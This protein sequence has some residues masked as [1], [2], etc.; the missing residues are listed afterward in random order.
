MYKNSI[1]QSRMSFS[2]SEST[3]TIFST[4]R[5]HDFDNSNLIAK[6]GILKQTIFMYSKTDSQLVVTKYFD[7]TGLCIEKDEFDSSKLMAITNYT[8]LSSLL[9]MKHVILNSN[10][11]YNDIIITYAYDGA[12]NKTD[13]KTFSKFASDSTSKYLLTWENE[14][15]YDSLNHLS[16]RYYTKNHKLYISARYYYNNDTLRLIENF[17]EHALNNSSD[18]YDYDIQLHIKRVYGKKNKKDLKREY[19]YDASNNLIKEV[20]YN[21]YPASDVNTLSYDYS[22]NILSSERFH[23]KYDDDIYFKSYYSKEVQ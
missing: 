4:P 15:K 5:P 9:T 13:E 2:F 22:N 17:N 10:S 18:Y 6:D 20:Q 1:G 16:G 7:S 21:S 3:F 8:Y 14:W 23:S 19:Y 11:S 12:G